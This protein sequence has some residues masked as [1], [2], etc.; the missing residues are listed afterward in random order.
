MAQQLRDMDLEDLISE[1][2]I[3]ACEVVGQWE[4]GGAKEWEAAERRLAHAVDE[5]MARDLPV[6]AH[7][8]MGDRP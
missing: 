7:P 6:N 4:V 5:L 2:A 8:E 3:A 1:Y